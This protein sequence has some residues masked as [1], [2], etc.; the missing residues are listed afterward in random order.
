MEAWYTRMPR[1]VYPGMGRMLQLRGTAVTIDQHFATV[2]CEL[3]GAQSTTAFCTECRASPQ[4]LAAKV[5]SLRLAVDR[6]RATQLRA[7]RS[8]TG[9]AADDMGGGVA[10]CSLNCPLYFASARLTRQASE[11]TAMHHEME[12]V[13]SALQLGNV[14]SRGCVD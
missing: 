7:C 5:L 8:C 14:S 6:Q 10:C 1:R 3:C 9:A 13:F 4:M 12:R 2:H 11:R